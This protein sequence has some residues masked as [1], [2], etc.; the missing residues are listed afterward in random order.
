[1]HSPAPVKIIGAGL[2]GSEA[3]LVL[4]AAGIPVDLVEMRPLRSSPA[5]TGSSFAELVCSNSLGSGKIET[6]KGLL[7]AELGALGSNLLA[8][9]ETVRVPAGMALAVDRDRFG[10]RVTSEVTRRSDIRVERIEQLAIPGD[11]VV[12]LACGPLP[13]DAM[14]GRLRVR[15]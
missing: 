8:I 12:I 11:P 15:T 4:S 2:A 6:G 14:G 5:H 13:S 3:A 10:D 7:K 1:M 9:A